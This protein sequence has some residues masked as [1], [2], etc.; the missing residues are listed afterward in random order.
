[1]RTVSLT[2]ALLGG[3]AMQRFGTVRSVLR[4]G[5]SCLVLGYTSIP[6]FAQIPIVVAVGE[7]SREE[8]ELSIYQLPLGQGLGAIGGGVGTTAALIALIAAAGKADR[9]SATAV[10]YLFRSLGGTVGLSVAAGIFQAVLR[11]QLALRL[12]GTDAEEV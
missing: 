3:V 9:A 4:T 5:F 7:R 2:S 8:I 10:S 11:Q 6:L 12:D 1:M